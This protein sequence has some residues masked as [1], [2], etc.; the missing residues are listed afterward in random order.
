MSC[1]VPQGK[2]IGEILKILLAE[3]IENKLKNEKEALLKRAI[4]IEK[5]RK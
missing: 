5:G 4:E 3:V 2:E 1:G